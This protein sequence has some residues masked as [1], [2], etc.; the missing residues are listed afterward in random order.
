VL[1]PREFEIRVI[2]LYFEH[3]KFSSFI[4]QANGWGFRRVI[5]GCDRNSYYHEM[6]L[7]GLPHLCKNMKR[8][9]ISEKQIVDPEHEPDLYKI[10][11]ALPVPQKA[12]DESILLNCTLQGGP[13]ARMPVYSG[14][15]SSPSSLDEP[16][17]VDQQATAMNQSQC[18]LSQMSDSMNF[19]SE[20]QQDNTLQMWQQAFMPTTPN[21][22]PTANMNMSG[23]APQQ[24]QQQHSS[25][26][27]QQQAT[28]GNQKCT[29]MMPPASTINN[30]A[31]AYQASS[32]ASQ[33]AAGF[34]AATAL[35]HQQLHSILEQV[36][37]V[38]N[39]AGPAVPNHLQNGHQ[40]VPQQGSQQYQFPARSN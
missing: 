17:W 7:R 34:A 1:K 13:K 16:Q 40:M 9:G 19:E 37:S 18:M 15:L 30:V 23:F 10:S 11:D 5:Q 3:A 36:M 28:S 24:Q 14:N 21:V 2:P 35:R 29:S 38:G 26:Q 4:R 8:P 12:E 27:Q 31:A 39:N 6:F 22:A 32:A 33:F 20:N 25:F